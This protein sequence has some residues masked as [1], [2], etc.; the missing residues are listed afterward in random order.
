MEF[1]NGLMK[2]REAGLAGTPAWEEAIHALVLLLAPSAPHLAEEL[3]ERLGRPYSV[4]QQSWP[5]W[6][7]ELAADEQIELVVQVNGKLRDRLLV[8]PGLDEAQVREAALASEK[9]QSALAGKPVR[10]LIVVPDKLVNVV[11]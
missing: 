1:V 7:R 9:V 5:Q 3:W 4:H 8:S 11:V 6:D 2:A 10:K